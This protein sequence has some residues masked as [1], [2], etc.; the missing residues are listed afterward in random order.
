[1]QKLTQEAEA[2]LLERFGGDS[3]VSLATQAEGIP[4][5]RYVDAFYEDGAFYVLTHGLSGKMRQIAKTPVVAVAGEWFTGH[6]VGENLGWF[7]KTENRRIAEKMKS[8]FA[9]WIDNGHNDLDDEN[10]CIL[11]IRL[12]GGVLFSNGRRFDIDFTV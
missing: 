3:I 2:I 12:T 5:V 4:Y 6:G 10:T 8:V 1:M 9:A 11:R 7:C